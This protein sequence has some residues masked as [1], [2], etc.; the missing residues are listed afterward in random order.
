MYTLH[1][2]QDWRLYRYEILQ[3][4]KADQLFKKFN[5]LVNFSKRFDLLV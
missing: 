3:L 1:T 4:T 2:P 5:L